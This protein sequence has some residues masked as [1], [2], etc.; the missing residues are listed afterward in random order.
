MRRTIVGLLAACLSLGATSCGSGVDNRPD[1][2][3]VGWSLIYW[4]PA[5]TGTPI[6][7]VFLRESA[8]SGDGTAS[9]DILLGPGNAVSPIETHSSLEPPVRRALIGVDG[10]GTIRDEGATADEL[11]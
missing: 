8:I 1:S 11:S 4:R 3:P 6:G 2:S 10:T 9:P 5:T 7:E